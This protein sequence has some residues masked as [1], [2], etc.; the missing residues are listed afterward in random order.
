M[1]I[2]LGAAVLTTRATFVDSR[3][4]ERNKPVTL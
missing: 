3:K 1:M 2:V 4:K